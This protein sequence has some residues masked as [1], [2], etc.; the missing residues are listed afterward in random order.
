MFCR[1]EL[2]KWMRDGG[3]SG[4]EIMARKWKAKREKPR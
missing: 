2:E 1:A 3:P 4:G